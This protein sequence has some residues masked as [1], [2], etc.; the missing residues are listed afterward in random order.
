VLLASKPT[1]GVDRALTFAAAEPLQ[2]TGQTAA[3]FTGPYIMSV[4][5]PGDPDRFGVWRLFDLSDLTAGNITPVASRLVNQSANSWRQLNLDDPQGALLGGQ[6]ELIPNDLG[7]PLDVAAFGTQISYIANTP[8]I[9]IQAIVPQ[10]MNA[11]ALATPQVD[12]TLLGLYRA[13]TT[14]QNR[15]LA[16]RQDG[17]DNTL[18]LADTQLA[19]V[20]GTHMLPIGGRPL[21]VTGLNNWPSRLTFESD[22]EAS[23]NLAVVMC[24]N[25]GMCV[26]PVDAA[27]GSFDP[28]LLSNGVGMINTP[29][30]SPQGAV[31]DPLSQLLFV[32]DGTAELTIIDLAVPGGSRD[33]DGD[34]VD[35]RVLGTVELEG[36][37]AQR[38]A[39]W[40]N[41][42]GAPVVAVATGSGG[43]SLVQVG[44]ATGDGISAPG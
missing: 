33:E 7:I 21:A 18:V 13:V 5:G 20:T 43:I 3:S 8:N 10:G 2:T 6:L 37:R 9:G 36:A 24:Q 40:Q 4:D 11:D 16:V 39:L 28:N 29:G 38:V 35:D 22:E 41:V 26:V 42:I 44:R 17:A 23:C 12:G 25:S 14:L 31:A 15:V 27:S 1:A 32:A 19:G 30:G 34:G